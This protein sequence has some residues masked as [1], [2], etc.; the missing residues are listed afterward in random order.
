MTFTS[1]TFVVFLVI[2]FTLYW[3][4]PRVRPQ[5]VLLAAA[6]FVFY[7][8]WD[9]RFCGL[10]IASSLT[11]FFLALAIATLTRPLARKWLVFFSVATNLVLLGFFK[12]FNFFQD[13]LV[14]G[15]NAIGWRVEP[16]VLDII[17][18]VG[19]SFY[20][21]QSLS[22]IV[23]VYRGDIAATRNPL[24]YLAYVAFFPQLVAGPIE[25]AT[26]LLPQFH[27]PR[28]FDRQSA[29]D[30]CRQ[31]LWGFAKKLIIADNLAPFVETAY[32]RPESFTGLQLLLATVFFAFQIYC[33][34][35]A[36]SDIAIG[37][38]KLFGFRLMRNF[39]YPYFSQD[40]VE[41]WRRWHISLSTWFRDYV[42]VP[43]GGSRTGRPTMMRNLFVTFLLSG[44]WHG[45]S[46]QFVA[47][48]IFHGVAV[49][50][51]TL[52]LAW[53]GQAPLR[54]TDVPGGDGW[55]PR[56]AVVARVL[57]TFTL[58]CIGWVF[59]RAAS[60][61]GAVAVLEGIATRPLH[62]AS[63]PLALVGPQPW[64]LMLSIIGLFLIWEW[65]QRHNH[66]G[67]AFAGGSRLL[68]WTLYT[69]LVWVTLYFYV[70]AVT[71]FIYFQF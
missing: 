39:A 36:Y 68:R 55:L 47:W 60:L 27:T 35:S 45:A 16:L 30:G 20:T 23:D 67:L 44:L 31:I 56:P 2:V 9:W 54:A 8:W 10:M 34:F 25:R 51:C 28:V 12:Y 66:H 7:G 69:A 17:L 1:M 58:V 64:T 18:P 43:L 52:W 14:A 49:G 70:G 48:G 26:N 53:R 46:W 19:I 29:V 11:D 15:L 50:V 42:Y 21:F 41:F 5:N 71:Q 65:G 37:T 13:N 40:I 6:S 63:E 3:V 4:L 59:F 33:D 61:T 32:S 62:T 24:D 38:A 22:Y 57:F